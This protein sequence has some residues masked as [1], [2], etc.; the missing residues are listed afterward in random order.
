MVHHDTIKKCGDSDLPKWVKRM[1]GQIKEREGAKEGLGE[2]KNVGGGEGESEL[3]SVA[4]EEMVE[5]IPGG[6][7]GY[8]QEDEGRYQNGCINIS[9]IVKS[10]RNIVSRVHTGQGK[11]G[12]TFFPQCQGKVREF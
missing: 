4:G 9:V 8:S 3:S 2:D 5:E 6:D 12:N 1:R 11:S 7:G 10:K